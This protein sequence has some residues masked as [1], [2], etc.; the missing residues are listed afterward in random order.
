MPEKIFIEGK[1]TDVERCRETEKEMAQGDINRSSSF[2]I[3]V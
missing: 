2:E 3:E 1:I